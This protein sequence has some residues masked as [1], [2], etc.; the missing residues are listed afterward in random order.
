MS[1]TYQ[2]LSHSKWDYKHHI[3]LLPKRKGAI[4]NRAHVRQRK[5]FPSRA[6]PFG[7]AVTLY[8]YRPVWF[9]LEQVRTSI[10]EQEAADGACGQF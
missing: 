7:P 8:L 9:E 1:K 3:I 5:K 2:S 10:R 6:S 4:A